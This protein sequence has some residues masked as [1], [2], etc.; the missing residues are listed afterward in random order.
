MCLGHDNWEPNATVVLRLNYLLCAIRKYYFSLVSHC[1][2]NRTSFNVGEG[3]G[4]DAF[5]G[6]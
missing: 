4:N 6:K 1:I 2:S 5:S 3:E